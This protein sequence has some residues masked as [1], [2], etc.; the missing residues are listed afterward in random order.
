MKKDTKKT[1]QSYTYM[2]SLGPITLTEE[3]GYITECMFGNFG[4]YDANTDL[5]D[6]AFA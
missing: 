3:D 2:T 1:L 6:E 4:Y 5:T